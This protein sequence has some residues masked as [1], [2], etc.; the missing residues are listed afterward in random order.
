MGAVGGGVWTLTA[1]H[2]VCVV[3]EDGDG[4]SPL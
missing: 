1:A 3:E 2:T 4:N